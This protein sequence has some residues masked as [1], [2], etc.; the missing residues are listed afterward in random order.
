M[1]FPKPQR[2]PASRPSVGATLTSYMAFFLLLSVVIWCAHGQGDSAE[3]L[4]FIGL[5]AGTA[6]ACFLIL[7]AVYWINW[8]LRAHVQ[9]L[10]D[11]QRNQA[12]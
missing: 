6:I 1:S 2:R 10:A 5:Y 8:I 7:F 11:Q 4:I 12:S 3:W 9:W